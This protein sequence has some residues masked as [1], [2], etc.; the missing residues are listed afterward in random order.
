MVDGRWDEM[1]DDYEMVDGD[2]L[3]ISQLTMSLR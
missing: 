2:Y 1:V 3:S